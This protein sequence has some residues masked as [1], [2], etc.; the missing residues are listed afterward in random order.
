[1]WSKQEQYMLLVKY[2]MSCKTRKNKIHEYVFESVFY[3]FSSELQL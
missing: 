2:R 3:F 1:M